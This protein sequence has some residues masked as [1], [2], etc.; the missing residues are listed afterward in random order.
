MQDYSKLQVWQKAHAVALTVYELTKRFPTEERYGLT[1]QIRR[2]AVSIAANIAEGCGRSSDRDFANFLHI[3]LGSANELGYFLLLARD[4]GMLGGDEQKE[5][6][7]RVEEIRRMLLALIAT[8]RR[9][10]RIRAT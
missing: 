2:G 6:G 8:V 7:Q 1:S 10:P 5:L 4:L 3:A 9:S